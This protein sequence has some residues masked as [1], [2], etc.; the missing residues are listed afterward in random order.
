VQGD[1]ARGLLPAPLPPFA[2]RTWPGS[3]APRKGST[4]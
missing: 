2:A 4:A 1:P 3:P